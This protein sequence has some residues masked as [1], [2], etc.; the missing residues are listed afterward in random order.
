[1]RRTERKW[2]E[3]PIREP[4]PLKCKGCGDLREAGE[5]KVCLLLDREVMA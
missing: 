1:M 4:E 2:R 5:C 3:V